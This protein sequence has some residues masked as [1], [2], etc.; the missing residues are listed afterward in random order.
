VQAT[1]PGADPG[2]VKVS[3]P[4]SR[5]LAGLATAPMSRTAHDLGYAWSRWRRYQARA[6]W[7]HY[8]AQLLRAARVSNYHSR[9]S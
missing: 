1:G 2:L 7:H 9:T 4:E 5:R 3:F 8:H 6:R